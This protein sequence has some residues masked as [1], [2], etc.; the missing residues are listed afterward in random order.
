MRNTI[1]LL[2]VASLLAAQAPPAQTPPA[3][4]PNEQA[5]FVEHFKFVLVPV[6]VTDRSGDVVN[7]LSPLDFVLTDNGRQQKIDEDV[8]THPLS[9]VVAIQANADTEKV[10][11]QIQRLAS[12]FESLVIGDNGELA[13]L[14]FDHRIQPLTD[15]TSDPKLI[16]AAFKKLRAGSYSSY[17]NE[18]AMTGVNM[19]RT[20]PSVRHR[21]MVIISENRDK[22]SHMKYREVLSAEGFANVTV[23]S[24]D[25][26]QLLSALTTQAQPPRPNPIPPEAR[27]LPGGAIGTPTTDSQNEMGNWVPALKEIFLAAK[28]LILPDPLDVY[29]KY[30]GGRQ[31]SFHSQKTLEKDIA[32]IGQELHSQYFLTYMPDN[33]N[34]AGFHEIKVTVKR[35][36]LKVRARDGYYIA[37]SAQ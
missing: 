10:L 1:T 21:V 36:G 9:V 4:N 26:S 6:T 15:F 5:T 17:L 33:Q 7:G 16:D 31:F 27:Q 25:V 30:T 29:T 3:E 11:P 18:A 20:R 22:G 23:Y 35:E 34:E 28:G 2:C 8:A 14:A 13:M 24:V 37:G 32:Q 12:A 19:L